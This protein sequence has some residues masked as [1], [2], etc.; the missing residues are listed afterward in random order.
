V[1][2]C[3][4]K[5][6]FHPHPEVPMYTVRVFSFLLPHYISAAAESLIHIPFA[7]HFSLPGVQ[8]N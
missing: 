7:T 5:E 8:P 4:A 2:Q 6:A 1:L 3:T